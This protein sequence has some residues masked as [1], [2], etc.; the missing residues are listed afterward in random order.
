[1]L[2]LIAGILEPFYGYSLDTRCHPLPS[3]IDKNDLHRRL[4]CPRERES[5]N[6]LSKP[7]ILDEGL[8]Q[9]GIKTGF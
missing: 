1:M 9:N 8:C 4:F 6:Q 2:Y 3:T 7:E 5:N